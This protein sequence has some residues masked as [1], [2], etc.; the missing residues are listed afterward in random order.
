MVEE[1][2]YPAR[3]R[4]APARSPMVRGTAAAPST[5]YCRYGTYTINGRTQCTP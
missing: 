1:G 5:T 4:A 3:V 2:S